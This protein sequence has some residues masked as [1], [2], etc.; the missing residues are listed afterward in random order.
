M[1]TSEDRIAGIQEV[2]RLAIKLKQN[3]F[4][5]S[6]AFDCC[7]AGFKLKIVDGG[8]FKYLQ[9]DDDTQIIL[10]NE[11]QALN[12]FTCPMEKFPV[13]HYSKAGCYQ[14]IH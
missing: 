4:C 7:E 1:L 6:E 3:V 5:G 11:M 13:T 14:K 12:F 10:C 8:F 9:L 2:I